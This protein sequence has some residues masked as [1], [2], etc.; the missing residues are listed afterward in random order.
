M[1][2]SHL[3]RVGRA[4][5]AATVLV[6]AATS[7]AAAVFAAEAGVAHA[8]STD[9]PASERPQ[10]HH[11]GAD[12][13]ASYG[14]VEGVDGGLEGMGD[15]GEARSVSTAVAVLD[16]ADAVP[17][18]LTASAIGRDHG[19]LSHD[20]RRDIYAAVADAPGRG[21]TT[22]ARVLDVNRSTARYHVKV[23]E[24]ADL[25]ERAKILGQCRLYPADF[26]GEP[27]LA[28]A[29]ADDSTEHL[30]RSVDDLEPVT[31]TGLAASVDRAASTTSRHVSRLEDAGLLERERGDGAV[32]V[33]VEEPVREALS[34]RA[35]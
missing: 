30:V 22:V 18:L 15:V 2:R 9:G 19:S 23:L 33:R 10:R 25:V 7:G 24:R 1:Y 4:L 8:A 11:L 13:V 35:D 14:G 21:L 12:G 16:P 34:A 3:P 20:T 32:M 6:A 31:I 26:D 28:A 29:L 5:L 27:A 17:G